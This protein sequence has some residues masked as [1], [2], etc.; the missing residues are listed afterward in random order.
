M[1]SAWIDSETGIEELLDGLKD[2]DVFAVDTESDHF[3]RYHP[4]VALIQAAQRD[5]VGLIDP[6]AVTVEELEPFFEVLEDPSIQKIMH[7]CRNDIGELDRDFR[8]DTVNV[9][10]TQV[11]ARFAGHERF[12]LDALLSELVG[13]K[14]Q[15]KFQRYDWMQRP[16]SDEAREYAAGDA[17]H[18]F[19]LRDVLH[20]ELVESGWIDAFGEQMEYVVSVSG[21]EETPFDPERW[22]RLKGAKE[23]G[24]PERAALAQLYAFRHELCDEL[25]RA[26]L[27]VIDNR[28]LIYLARRRPST[29]DELEDV[30]GLGDIVDRDARLRLLDALERGRSGEEPPAKLRRERSRRDPQTHERSKAIGQFRGKLADELGIPV[31]F[32]LSPAAVS[33]IAEDPPTSLAELRAKRHVLPWQVDEFGEELLAV[34][35]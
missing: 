23:L 2:G 20:A 3:F 26:A 32:V 5:R 12:G 1:K 16:I 13:V 35:D 21:Y 24:G 7:S 27:H 29:L 10:D 11:A 25:D 22:R 17:V 4:V 18:L 19:A 15:K 9:F 8:V 6:H 14:V 34:L 30:R 31:E 33:E 28:T